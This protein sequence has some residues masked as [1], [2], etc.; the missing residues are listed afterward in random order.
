MAILLNYALYKYTGTFCEY[1]YAASRRGSASSLAVVC[2][3]LFNPLIHKRDM[4]R[5][6]RTQMSNLI[7]PRLNF[8]RTL[9]K[10][11]IRQNFCI[12]YRFSL[13]YRSFSL[14][15]IPSPFPLVQ[16]SMALYAYPD[17]V[18]GFIVILV[19]SYYLGS[20]TNRT[21]TFFQNTLA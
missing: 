13:L 15:F 9:T 20:T 19:V 3:H 7:R 17:N 18:K 6:S 12:N 5:A 2:E 11:N 14:G 8:Q 10:H 1:A 21:N 4:L 16:F